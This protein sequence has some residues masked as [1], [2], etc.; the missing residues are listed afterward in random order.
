VARKSQQFDRHRAIILA[1]ILSAQFATLLRAEEYPSVK[2]ATIT[3]SFAARPAPVAP[4][5]QS[6]VNPFSL[7]TAAT[8]PLERPQRGPLSRWKKPAP[9]LDLAIQPDLFRANIPPLEL[10]NQPLAHPLT[11]PSI[12]PATTEGPGVVEPESIASIAADTPTPPGPTNWDGVRLRQPEWLEPIDTSFTFLP[13]RQL[14]KFSGAEERLQTALNHPATQ[15]RSRGRWHAA[16]EEPFDPFEEPT[17][18][19]PF[20]TGELTGEIEYPP[21]LAII[22][23]EEEIPAQSENR[24]VHPL[25]ELWQFAEVARSVDDLSEVIRRCH[26]ELVAQSKTESAVALCQLASWSYNARGEEFSKSGAHQ[27]ALGDFQTALELD[28]KNWRAVHNRAVSL[29][30][31]QRYGP[32]LRDFTRTIELNPA[33]KIAY[34]NRGELLAALDRSAEAINDYTAALS[35]LPPDAELYALRA[36][37]QHRLCNYQQAVNDFDESLRISPH[38]PNA[39]TGRGNLHVEI[40]RYV[41]AIKDFQLAVQADSGW[42]DA[43]R[44][45]AWLLATCPAE[46]FRNP[47][48]AMVA[49]RK[50]SECGQ[51]NDPFVLDALAAAAASG[52]QYRAAVEFEQ[53]AIMVAPPELLPVFEHR[54]ALYEQGKPFVSSRP[55]GVQATSYQR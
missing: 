20:N 45:L 41:D 37:A 14:E 35:G 43:Y 17:I 18:D 29:A 55:G 22:V 34:R 12:D 27:K 6:V 36:H 38:N 4:S 1:T 30:D 19:K 39:L 44:S 42:G 16:D 3:N 33:L 5:R 15:P 13:P 47:Q 25:D 11:S 24:T 26:Q 10:L 9:G 31:Q 54:L 28:E 48:Q 23:P 8:T 49:A 7:E 52:R 46:R 51:P 50:A 2:P 32:A 53:R 40:G 21:W